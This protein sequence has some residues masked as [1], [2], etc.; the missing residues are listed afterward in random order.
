MEYVPN[1]TSAPDLL[2]AILQAGLIWGGISAWTTA[3]ENSLTYTFPNKKETI[4]A[5]VIYASIVTIIVIIL[6]LFIRESVVYYN[7]VAPVIA[8]DIKKDVR[9][10]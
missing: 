9:S 6:V 3:I 10:L 1:D 8:T 5:Q 7:N 2:P 4:I